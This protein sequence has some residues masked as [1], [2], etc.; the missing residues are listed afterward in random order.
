MVLRSALL[1]LV[2]LACSS[3]A[4]AVTDARPA[5]PPDAFREEAVVHPVY[6]TAPVPAQPLAVRLCDTVRDLPARRKAACCHIPEQ[7][8][9]ETCVHDLSIA[10][11]D[12]AVTVEAAEL[13]A[14]AA[15]SDAAFAGCDWVRPLPPPTPAAC[16]NLIHGHVKAGAA[17]RSV[18]ECADGLTCRGVGPTDRGVCAPPSPPGSTCG[19]SVDALAAMA[20]QSDASHPSCVG[21]C[22]HGGRCQAFAAAGA[23]CLTSLACGPGAH[24]AAGVCATGPLPGPD[25]V[26][27]DLCKDPAICIKGTCH[28]PKP[29][30]ATCS[31]PFEC[32]GAC[33][34]GTCAAKCAP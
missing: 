24:C 26:C 18:L 19:A 1:A 32:Q 2:G 9:A 6:P 20:G 8:M 31:S 29:A 11:A 13:D 28:E 7:T 27:T 15:A 10:L 34:N 25:E 22:P 4:P 16:R 5:P 33:V 23:A 21:F 12:G 3:R 14:C 30:G 17:C